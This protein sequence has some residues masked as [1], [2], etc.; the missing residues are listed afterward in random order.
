MSVSI[1]HCLLGVWN[2]NGP[3]LKEGAVLGGGRVVSGT[4]GKV[5]YNPGRPV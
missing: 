5:K 4:G 2:E 3:V 1:Y